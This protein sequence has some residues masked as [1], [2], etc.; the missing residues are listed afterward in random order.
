MEEIKDTKQTSKE[1]ETGSEK[2]GASGLNTKTTENGAPIGDSSEKITEVRE[3]K[4]DPVKKT[5]A[6]GA[7][8]ADSF[9][10]DV[11]AASA[12]DVK[13][14]GGNDAWADDGAT[15]ST[16]AWNERDSR[17]D[18]VAVSASAAG[19]AKRATGPND[20]SAGDHVSEN[21]AVTVGA[22]NDKTGEGAAEES[23]P[24][25]KKKKK[26]SELG[27]WIRDI[28]IAI[29]IALVI[30]QFIQPTIVQEH[31]M[32]NTLQ[33]YDYLILSKM[34]YKFGEIGYGDIIVFRSD[35]VD[36]DGD[37]KLLIKRVI[38]KGGDTIEI[39]DGRVYRNGEELSEPY[40]KDGYTSGGID[41]VTVPEGELFLMG[42]NRVASVDSRDPAVGFVDED[43][44]IGKAVLRLFPFSEFGSVY[45]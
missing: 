6:I 26:G 38:A 35:M 18:A 42:D 37:K 1:A 43:R 11:A 16:S 27:V 5:P 31:S 45:K 10:Q 36:D 8:T 30:A 3:Q 28:L 32:Q 13:S 7:Q 15:D 12:D 14:S 34:S 41:E 33:P 44:V 39:S 20:T 29:A 4:D 23:E 2:S 9:H 40:T 22:K 21:G 24:G 25:G 19:A 17:E